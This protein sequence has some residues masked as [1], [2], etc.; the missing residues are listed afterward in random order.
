MKLIKRHHKANYSVTS[1]AKALG[2]SRSSVSEIVNGHTH[3]G[4]E[5]NPNLPPFRKIKLDREPIRPDGLTEREARRKAQAP[6]D[7]EKVRTMLD[8]LRARARGQNGVVVEGT[9]RSELDEKPKP[10]PRVEAV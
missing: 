7:P 6:P 10:T 1:I 3:V 8:A 4:I 2:V 9:F 5:D